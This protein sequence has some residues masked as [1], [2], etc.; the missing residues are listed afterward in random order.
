M[1]ELL[2]DEQRQLRDSAA[3]LCAARGGA[4]RARDLREAGQDIDAQAWRAS[5]D[6]GWLGMMVPESRG[7]LGLGA[8]EFYIVLEQAGR[9]ALMTPLLETVAIAWLFGAL[10]DAPQALAAMLTSPFLS[11]AGL[12]SS[13]AAR[14]ACWAARSNISPKTIRQT[15]KQVSAVRA[16]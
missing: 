16:S 1:D 3:K 13:A 9:Q 7:G 4:K 15:P 12:M 14:A 11:A 8:V 2:T 5:V 10:R 6:A